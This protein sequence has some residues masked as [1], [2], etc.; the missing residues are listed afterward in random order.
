MKL[1]R[2][3]IPQYQA[4]HLRKTSRENQRRSRERRNSNSGSFNFRLSSRESLRKKT[5]HRDSFDGSRSRFESPSGAKKSIKNERKLP[6]SKLLQIPDVNTRRSRDTKDG[7]RASKNS[8]KPPK[9]I[10]KPP[11]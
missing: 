10:H 2:V 6:L 1:G 5:S 9:A 8:Y 11:K 7:L 4:V 3:E